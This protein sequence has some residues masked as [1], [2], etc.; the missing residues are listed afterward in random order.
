MKRD[1][2]IDLLKYAPSTIVP[3][4]VAMVTF[5]II[6]RLLNPAQYGQFVLVV[7]WIPLLVSLSTGWVSMSTIRFFP[8]CEKE[9]RLETYYGTILKLSGGGVFVLS[10]LLLSVVGLASHWMK[11]VEKE[12]LLLG[13][14]LFVGGSFHT[15]LTTM[16]R[17]ERRIGLYSFAQSWRSIVDPLLGIGLASIFMAGVYGFLWGTLLSSLAVIPLLWWRGFSRWNRN[18]RPLDINLSR[19]FLAYGLP[20]AGVGIS[21]AVLRMGDRYIIEYLRASS[22][23][24]LYSAAYFIAESSILMVATLIQ[25]ATGPLSVSVWESRGKEEARRFTREVTRLYLIVMVPAV[26][27]LAALAR[28][29]MVVL[30]EEKYHGAYPLIPIIAAGV[31]LLGL[32]QRFQI[33]FVLSKKT[34]WVFVATAIAGVVNLAANFLLIPRWGMYG[35][36]WATVLGYS[37]MLITVVFA[38]LP[39]FRFPF[40][41]AT[42]VRTVLAS[43]AMAFA[44]KWT[45]HQFQDLGVATLLSGVAVGM[46]SYGALMA[47]LGEF[48]DGFPRKKKRIPEETASDERK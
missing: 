24:G 14:A 16:L 18:P 5:P 22:D 29:T 40:P 25:M 32:Q 6:T 36:A 47:L 30:T 7:S 11:G 39:L 3:P 4:L 1:V 34:A 2:L 27:G 23:V 12:M 35:A 26:F 21:A 19:Q 13:I 44:V 20:L 41:V 46:A 45:L 8:I 43:I 10:V 31:F 15:L 33:A 38:S 17:A 48:A 42:L 28:A 9:G 37:V